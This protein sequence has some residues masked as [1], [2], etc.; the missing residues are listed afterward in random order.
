MALGVSRSLVVLTMT[1]TS[2][3]IP[4]CS[5]NDAAPP[6]LLSA[7]SL[8][9]DWRE[10]PQED[11]APL[12]L[13]GRQVPSQSEM[14]FSERSQLLSEPDQSSLVTHELIKYSSEQ[15]ALQ[16]VETFVSSA[17]CTGFTQ[18]DG[19]GVATMTV[20][21]DVVAGYSDTEVISLLYEWADGSGQGAVM[22]ATRH[23]DTV[24]YLTIDAVQGGVPRDNLVASILGV[25]EGGSID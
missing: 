12:L 25:A 15:A 4:A 8:T 14:D 10:L 22:T 3:C 7:S 23:D 2:L 24:S 19:D 20:S 9:G 18:P 11:S 5:E 6:S 17:E 21:D 13:C 1:A 16:A